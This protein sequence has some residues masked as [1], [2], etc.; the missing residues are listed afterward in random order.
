MLF[1]NNR[2]YYGRYSAV[3]QYGRL[4]YRQLGFL[5]KCLNL[6]FKFYLCCT[7]KILVELEISYTIGSQQ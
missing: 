4:S 7:N 3:M 6:V 1:S 2:Y 5:F